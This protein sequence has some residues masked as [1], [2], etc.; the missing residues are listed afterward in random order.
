MHTYDNYFQLLRSV[1]ERAE[2]GYFW[3]DFDRYVYSFDPNRPEEEV[4]VAYEHEGGDT[5][6]TNGA[7]LQTQRTRRLRRFSAIRYSVSHNHF[8]QKTEH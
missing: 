5:E 7:V 3:I 6:P 2:D 8:V 1:Y 4:V